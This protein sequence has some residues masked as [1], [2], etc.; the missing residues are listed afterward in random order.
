MSYYE[1]FIEGG[2][3][4]DNYLKVTVTERSNGGQKIT[5]ALPDGC[6]RDTGDRIER[7]T[8]RYKYY[9]SVED[10]GFPL[11]PNCTTY[12]S[13][14]LLEITDLITP[15]GEYGVAEKLAL[16]PEPKYYGYHDGDAYTWFSGTPTS[17][18]VHSPL[19]T[20]SLSATTVGWTGPTTNNALDCVPMPGAV[21]VYSSSDYSIGHVNI[22][23]KVDIILSPDRE[24]EDYYISCSNSG[25][26]PYDERDDEAR[27]N[28]NWYYY[29]NELKAS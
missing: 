18:I 2:T 19:Y 7:G 27:V 10:V 5:L 6:R 16:K 14:R 12:A 17:A 3:R 4:S 13:G 25:W 22:V 11:L 9:Q 29:N 20:G 28:A 23:E 21:A 15:T 1:K 26:V 24:V 8:A